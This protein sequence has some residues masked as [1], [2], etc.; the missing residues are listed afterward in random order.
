MLPRPDR[1]GEIACIG[2]TGVIQQATADAML[3][4]KARFTTDPF[5][6]VC[7][8]LRL[9]FLAFYALPLIRRPK[10]A[11]HGKQARNLNRR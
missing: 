7:V 2:S 1:H 10:R 3:R 11:R 8:H 9:Y 5:A 6:F 4:S